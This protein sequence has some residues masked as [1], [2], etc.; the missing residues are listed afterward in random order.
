MLGMQA[1]NHPIAPFLLAA[2]MTFTAMP[3]PLHAEDSDDSL[4]PLIVRPTEGVNTSARTAPANAEASYAASAATYGTTPA[5]GAPT[6]LTGKSDARLRLPPAPKA[7][8]GKIDILPA[9]QKRAGQVPTGRDIFLDF[10]PSSGSAVSDR[11]IQ[12]RDE[13]VALRQA[14]DRDTDAFNQLRGQG[15]SGAI[16]YHS[17]VAAISARLE[18][19]TTRGNPILLRQWSEAEQSLSEVNYS[20]SKLNVMATNLAGHAASAAYLLQAVKAA[21]ELSGAV[22]E[23]HV[24]LAMIRDEV[25]RNIIGVDHL[26]NEINEDIRRQNTY[27]TTERQNLQALAVAINRGELIRNSF[28]GQ[29]VV[30]GNEPLYG[31]LPSTASDN[32]GFPSINGDSTVMPPP[33]AAPVS[34]VN[35]SPLPRGGKVSRKSV[36]YSQPDASL[37]QLLVLVRFNEPQVAYEDQLYQAVSNALDRKPDASFTVV[38]V[39]PKSLDPSAMGSD[40][41]SAQRNAEN[42]KSS[43]I[44]LGLQPS[45][46]SMSSVPSDVAQSPEVHLYIR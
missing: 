35:K 6:D 1:K 20:I 14:I 3:F 36:S 32:S 16:Q 43:L 37:G 44:Q 21:F 7:T 22:D 45:R 31:S 46:I 12:L 30:M 18:S 40:F 26:R 24:Q 10:G 5:A 15:A 23:D 19:G 41:E 42:V 2:A 27:L 25:S 33:A 28:A 39:N 9:A 13:S 38:A 34:P 17:T 8:T 11:V 29:A 4:R